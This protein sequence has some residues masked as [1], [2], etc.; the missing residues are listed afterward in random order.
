M[1]LTVEHCWWFSA[2]SC[3][4]WRLEKV[5]KIWKSMEF[6]F[7][8]FAANP[9]PVSP[10]LIWTVGKCQHGRFPQV[11]E[12]KRQNTRKRNA[13]G[14]RISGQALP[15]RG[16]G[17]VRTVLC[18]LKA[19][20]MQVK[21]RGNIHAY[22]LGRSS[23][24]R[25]SKNGFSF[26]SFFSKAPTHAVKNN[27]SNS[28][29]VL[30]SHQLH[31]FPTISELTSHLVWCRGD[32]IVGKHRLFSKNDSEKLPNEHDGRG[33]DLHIWK[34]KFHSVRFGEKAAL[35]VDSEFFLFVFV[36]ICF[37]FG[38]MDAFRCCT[39]CW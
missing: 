11:L 29:S 38:T 21:K 12:N 31:F 14:H 23:H 8:L 16:L 6:S 22:W 15:E 2:V 13:G 10:G 3:L 17:I 19:R 27:W 7:Q 28:R 34:G 18:G 1:R 25:G 37:G 30:F 32:V 20:G 33:L 35:N 4:S 36:L 9:A 26:V 39:F 24:S 5:G